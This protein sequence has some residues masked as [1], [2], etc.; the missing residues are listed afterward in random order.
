M[1]DTYELY[2][3]KMQLGFKKFNFLFKYT[4]THF[5]LHTHVYDI[6]KVDGHFLIS[7]AFQDTPISLSHTLLLK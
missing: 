5:L 1:Y 2:F 4:H 3:L 7:G 6:F